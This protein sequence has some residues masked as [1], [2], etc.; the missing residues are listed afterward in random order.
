MDEDRWD[1]KYEA[2]KVRGI[3]VAVCARPG[4]VEYQVKLLGTCEGVSEIGEPFIGPN[5]LRQAS[6]F[7]ES[8]K[9]A[10]ECAEITWVR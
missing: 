9:A 7:S 4:S 3:E 2:G 5:A 8:I 10:M 6:V 1:I